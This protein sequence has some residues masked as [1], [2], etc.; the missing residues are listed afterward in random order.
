MEQIISFYNALNVSDNYIFLFI[1]M[2]F[3]LATVINKKT[4][5]KENR[6]YYENMLKKYIEKGGK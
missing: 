2:L 1:G 4:E 3:G 6:E 5:K